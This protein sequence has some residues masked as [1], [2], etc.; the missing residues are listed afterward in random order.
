MIESVARNC[1]AL[2]K[3]GIGLN[4]KTWHGRPARESTRK[5]RVPR[6][7]LLKATGLTMKADDG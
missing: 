5:M 4:L 6:K 2:P 1:Q 3:P 7:K